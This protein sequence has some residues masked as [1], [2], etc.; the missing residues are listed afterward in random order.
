MNKLDK[1]RFGSYHKRRLLGLV[2]IVA[3]MFVVALGMLA[4]LGIFSYRSELVT[5]RLSSNNNGSYNDGVG[6]NINEIPSSNRLSYS[7]FQR[8]K[9]YQTF[10]VADCFGDSIF[11]DSSVNLEDY[12]FEPGSE[13]RVMSLDNDGVMSLR[14]AGTINSFDSARFGQNIPIEDE[15]GNWINDTVIDVAT[16]SG[17]V[18]ALTSNGKL[19]SDITSDDFVR[20]F[21]DENNP[22]LEFVGICN[23]NDY[24]YALSSAGDIYISTDGRVFSLF[25]SFAS[26]EN[27]EVN[28]RTFAGVG[29][30]VAVIT[31]DN[32]YYLVSANEINEVSVPFTVDDDTVLIS[33]SDKLLVL[34][35]NG[36]A[37]SSTNGFVFERILDEAGLF[38]ADDNYID[39]KSVGNA[40]YFLTDYGRLVVFN[41]DSISLSHTYDL[42]DI[43][44]LM[45]EVTPS[46]SIIAVTAD[47]RACLISEEGNISDLSNSIGVIDAVYCGVGDRLILECGNNLYYVT[48]LSAIQVDTA[49]PENSVT[50]GD[51]CYIMTNTSGAFGES[52]WFVSSENTA[53]SFY[54]NYDSLVGNS[55]IRMFG[56]D[57]GVH[58]ISQPLYGDATDN[59]SY[60]TFYRISL[61]LRTDSTNISNVKVW[62][63]GESFGEEGFVVEDVTTKDNSFSYVFALTGSNSIVEGDKLYFNISYEGEGVLYIDNVYLGEDRYDSNTIPYDYES[64]IVGCN[65][66]AIRLNNLNFCTNGNSDEIFYGLGTNS[67]QTSLSLV[68]EADSNPW[69]VVGSYADAASVTNFMAYF[70]GSVSSEYGK[71]RI[72]NGTAIPWS[73]QFDTIYIEI[74]D[75]DNA[76]LTDMQRGA[77][78]SYVKSLFAQSE[79]YSEI[80]DRVVFIDG[81][82]YEGGIVMSSADFH[83]MPAGITGSALINL[84]GYF[85]ELNYEVPRMPMIGLDVGEYISSFTYGVEYFPTVGAYAAP[86]VS[87]Y[88]SFVRATLID[89]DLSDRPIDT[90]SSAIFVNSNIQT[91]F[92]TMACLSSINNSDGLYYDIIDPL[93]TSS[94]QSAAQFANDCSISLVERQGVTYLVVANA[95][96]A[97]QQFTLEGVNGSNPHMLRYSSD[98]VCITDRNYRRSD[99]RITLQAGEIIVISYTNE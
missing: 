68:K 53:L 81:M 94:N 92:N 11:F 20:V 88:S 66:S 25:N 15:D 30:T 98:G 95:S 69:F 31:E 22:D 7:N 87:N 35:S 73:R 97:Q 54:S 59:F 96:N 46:N 60:N 51:L 21:E 12:S 16:S 38:I 55:S 77:Y 32:R 18:V 78:V 58:A 67:L 70:C 47:K 64:S 26:D 27:S 71:Y 13:I 72:D 28:V 57:D 23:Y 52:N 62:I 37:Y 8:E 4:V 29:N 3:T 63:Y 99:V 45:V 34:T 36:E 49:I 24:I 93:D 2:I 1:F 86:I 6:L 82:N 83:A 56:L 85:D 90:E 65:P 91:I 89:V 75:S 10:T 19:V 44:P 33:S 42:S 79:F 41:L 74:L 5:I 40:F 61:N 76:Y 43:N 84:K 50:S 48:V 17:S 80:K 39:F 14:Y 9:S